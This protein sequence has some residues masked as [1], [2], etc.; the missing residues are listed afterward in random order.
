MNNCHRISNID[1]S[2]SERFDLVSAQYYPYLYR[3]SDIIIKSNTLVLGDAFH[4]IIYYTCIL[5]YM[6]Q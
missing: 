5:S 4:I 1:T 3:V 2:L 6:K